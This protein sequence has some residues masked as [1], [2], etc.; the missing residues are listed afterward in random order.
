MIDK[1]S[2]A[3]REAIEAAS[4][5]SLPDN[6]SGRGMT[7]DKI[8]KKFWEPLTSAGSNLA[9]E[10]DRVAKEANDDIE[11][12]VTKAEEELSDEKRERETSE[13]GI[14]NEI[15]AVSKALDDHKA[16]VSV[17]A[18]DKTIP[19]RTSFGTLE[20]ETS[21][22]SVIQYPRRDKQLINLG[23]F[24]AEMDAHKADVAKTFDTL[25]A[26]ING[27]TTSYVIQGIVDLE[28]N[29]SEIGAKLKTGDKIFSI[30]KNIPDL[31]FESKN[32]KD[33]M[34]TIT[35]KDDDGIEH[36]IELVV[37]ESSAPYTIYGILHVIESNAVNFGDLEA[38]LDSIIA[39]Q[40][41]LIGG[42]A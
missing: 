38:V 39:Y 1:I 16:E 9:K 24:D 33:G 17:E 12:A 42:G 29:L 22:I 40:E 14:R 8:R 36:T 18:V 30:D 25:E 6:P 5:K 23:F 3:T 35:V 19:R 15:S 37:M 41:Q 26:Q 27:I 20:A 4:A 11:A 32:N 7:P 13:N 28:S 10:I 21:R 34:E 2:N 31:W